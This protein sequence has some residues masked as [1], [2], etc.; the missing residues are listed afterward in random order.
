MIGEPCDD[1]DALPAPDYTDYIMPHEYFTTFLPRLQEAV[2]GIKVMYEEKAKLK[3]EQVRSL[4]AAWVIEI[5]PGIEAISTG[6]LKLM[7]KGTT[8]GQN[9]NLLR[10]AKA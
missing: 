9:I 7:G 3:L 10:Y 8:A 6:L 1:L 4:V 5:Q 2:P